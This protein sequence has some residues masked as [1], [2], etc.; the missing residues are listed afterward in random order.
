MA[1]TAGDQFGHYK[2]L[3][4]IGK[5]G[6]GEVYRALDSTL[7]RDVAVKILLRPSRATL[8]AWLASSAKPKCWLR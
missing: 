4:L 7:D 6:M 3:S 2:I 5:G 1:L 8:A